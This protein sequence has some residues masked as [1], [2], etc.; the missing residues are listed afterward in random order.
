MS[1]F[2]QRI[3]PA[4][5]LAVALHTSP[6]VLADDSFR[7]TDPLVVTH[8]MVNAWNALDV[9]AIVAIFSEDAHFQS[10]MKE[11]IVGRAE[12][13]KHFGRLLQNASHLELKLRHVAVTGNTVFVERIDVFTVNG[14]PGSVPVVAVMDIEDG[15]VARWREYYDRADLLSEMGV[16]QGH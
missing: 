5:V 15:Y 1:I 16:T 8:N 11:P 12:L 10:M 3:L 13:K 9:D 4:A 2:T 7:A 6:G 14:K